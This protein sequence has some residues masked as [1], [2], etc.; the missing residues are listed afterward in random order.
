[1]E[2]G[3]AAERRR[4]RT[5]GD[6]LDHAETCR[7]GQPRRRQAMTC[8]FLKLQQAT[9]VAEQHFA[10]VGQRDA[11]RC[12]PEQGPFGFELE[13]LDLLAYRRL[14]QVEPLRGAVET[15]AIGDGNEGAQQFEVQHPIDPV[16]RSIIL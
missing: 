8:R 1:M 14:G 5:A 6:L 10:I 2:L 16:C 13:P 12:P 15:A 7:A 4:E 3:E 9:R 11:T